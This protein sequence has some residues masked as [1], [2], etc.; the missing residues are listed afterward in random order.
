LIIC[1]RRLFDFEEIC[2][3]WGNGGDIREA[4]SPIYKWW[5]CPVLTIC[6]LSRSTG[7]TSNHIIEIEITLTIMTSGQEDV[8]IELQKP[9]ESHVE[10]LR[11]EQSSFEIPHEIDKTVDRKFD[12]HIIP[13]LFGIWYVTLSNISRSENNIDFLFLIGY[14]HS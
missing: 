10:E 9:R 6:V 4:G 2:G 8:Q 13:W 12:R 3:V 11:R 14:L 5:L 1:W 7:S